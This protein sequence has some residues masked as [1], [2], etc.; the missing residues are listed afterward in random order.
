MHWHPNAG[1]W[2]YIIK[3]SG[4]MTV[5]NTRPQ[6][7][8]ANFHPGDIGYIKKSL[9][10]YLENTGDTELVYMEVFRA[11]RF[12]EVALS[13]WLAHTPI[14]M[15]AETLNLD[16]SVIARFPKDWPAVVPA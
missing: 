7:V 14:N 5:F 16:P 13:D 15:V 2:L 8:T 1:E 12:A 10:H 6:A 11:E 3:G 4:R 9:G